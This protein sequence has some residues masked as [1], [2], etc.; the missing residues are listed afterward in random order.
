MN[1]AAFVAK[2][3][4]IQ[5]KERATAQTHFNDVCR[6]VGHPNITGEKHDRALF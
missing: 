1:P 4:R 5:Q 6:L 3:S 2:W